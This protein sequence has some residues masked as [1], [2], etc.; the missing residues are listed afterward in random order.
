MDHA[1]HH[2]HSC[3]SQD[4][5][6]KPTPFYRRPSVIWTAI[7]AVFYLASYFVPALQHFRHHFNDYVNHL[8]V[9]ILLG[10]V[11]GGIV[12]YY[13]PAEYI[14]KYLTTHQKR[15]V[16]YAAGLGFLMSACSHGILALSMELHK[17]GASGPAVI[18]FLL[19]SPWAN[20]P[21]TFLLIG[22][23]GMKGFLII[24]LAFLIAISTGLVFQA[25]DRKG[26]IEKNRHTIRVHEAFSISKDIAR[27][28]KNKKWNLA[29]LQ[30]DATGIIRGSIN[31]ADMIFTWILLGMLLASLAGSL[32]PAGIFQKYFGPSI[33]GLGAT[34]L[35][36]I[37]IEVCSEGT[38]PLAFEIY[39]QTGALGNA[40]AFLMGGVVTDYT[41]IGLVWSRLGRRT[42]LW[43]IA[44]SLPQ[45]F[46]WGWIL[47][48]FFH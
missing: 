23:F 5:N 19:A 33:L 25:L 4:E 41:E 34:M 20:L 35:A 10:L 7:T 39:K 17:K 16:L 48:R 3:C 18:S 6:K 24:V 28:F 22:F 42:A 26:W 13:I 44:V 46:L 36:A 14:S 37:V 45:V 1:S 12:D 40:F 32:I 15:T 27:R 29:T 9:P 8:L 31:L 11:I 43:L 30:H 2:E 38:A 47:N 21:I